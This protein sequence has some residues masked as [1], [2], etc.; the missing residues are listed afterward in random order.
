MNIADFVD[1]WTCQICTFINN[2]HYYVCSMCKHESNEYHIKNYGVH[3]QRENKNE[4]LSKTFGKMKV[5]L[6][7]IHVID[8]EQTLKCLS[9]CFDDVNVDGVFLVNNFCSTKVLIDVYKQ[10]KVNYPNRWIGLNILGNEFEALTIYQELQP[11][12]IWLDNAGVYDATVDMATFIQSFIGKNNI[13]SLYFGGICF[14]Y[15]RQPNNAE[16]T[17]KNAY[18]F[19][20]VVTTSGNK[21]GE[22]IDNNKII[23]I[24]NG[25][26]DNAPIAIASGID[27]NNIDVI[28]RYTN[29]FIMNTNLCENEIFVKDRLIEMKNKI[30]SFNLD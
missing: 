8:L 7:V 1:E 30:S 25:V 21:T 23:D 15:C 4:K 3:H 6:P 27:I 26:N 16:Q 22:C 28:A 14:K 10:V 11:S 9:I 2:N 19:M 29:V 12:G 18:K 13:S 17:A 24:Y 20:D 5:F